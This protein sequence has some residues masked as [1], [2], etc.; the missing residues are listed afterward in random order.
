MIELPLRHPELFQRLGVEPPKGVLLFGPPGTGKSTMAR[1]IVNTLGMKEVSALK[2]LDVW[3]PPSMLEQY[4][5][6]SYTLDDMRKYLE[7]YD[8]PPV[9]AQAVFEG[10]PYSAILF[11]Q[12]G[13]LRTSTWSQSYTSSCMI[14]ML[15]LSS[16]LEEAKPPGMGWIFQESQ[17]QF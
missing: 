6:P 7:V 15:I 10:V 13:F 5:G 11:D 4:D 9:S 1:T 17:H 16:S 14:P 2:L 8:R 12:S 3:F